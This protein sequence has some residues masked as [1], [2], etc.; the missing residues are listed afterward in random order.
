MIVFQNYIRLKV[1]FNLIKINKLKTR[2]FVSVFK[3]VNTLK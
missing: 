3:R 2:K 1:S